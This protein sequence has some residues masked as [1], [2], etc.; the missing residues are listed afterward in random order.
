MHTDAMYIEH[1]KSFNV[2]YQ[3]IILMRIKC[4]R[5][6]RLNTEIATM[7]PLYLLIQGK[8]K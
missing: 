6:V 3:R 4:L 5:C 1:A 2:M 8:R 7:L